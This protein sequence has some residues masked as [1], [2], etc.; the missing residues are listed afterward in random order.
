MSKAAASRGIEDEFLELK[1]G[2]QAKQDGIAYPVFSSV[3]ISDSGMVYF[4]QESVKQSM[5]ANIAKTVRFDSLKQEIT[6][7]RTDASLDKQ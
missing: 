6:L 2:E 4:G 7:G 1:L 5:I 3:F